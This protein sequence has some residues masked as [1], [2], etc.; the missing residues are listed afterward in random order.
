MN[1]SLYKVIVVGG[2]HAGYEA[3]LASARM[4]VKTL[5]ITLNKSLIGR[6]PCNPAVGGIAKSHLVSELDAL[7]GELG[8]NTDYTGIQYRML[9]TRKGPAVQSNRVQC[10]K[11]LFPLRIQS[12]LDM[13]ENLDIHDDIVT[14]IRTK[15]AAICGVTTRGGGDIDADAVVICTGTFLRGRVLI[16]TKS[17]KEGRMGEESAEELSASFSRFG[18]E[19]GRLKTG[20]PPRIHRDSVDYSSMEIQPGEEPPPFF[21]R[22]ARKE[23]KMFHVEHENPDPSLM[24][25][26]FHVEHGG[27]HPWRPGSDQIPCWL[28]HT[29]A[30]THQIIAD[31]LH[32]SA[33]YSGAVEGTGVRYCPSIEDKIVK[34]SGRDSHHVFIEPEGRNNIRLYP[35]GTS[36]SL[37]EDVQKQMIHSIAGLEKAEIIRPAYAIE[38]D[39]ANPTQLFHTLETKRVENL[40]FAGQLNGTTGYEEAAGQGFVAGANAALK[41]LGQEEFTLSRNESYIGVLIDDLVTKGTDEPYRMFT[42]RSEH[43]LTLRQDNVYFRLLEK[44][45]QLNIVNSDELSEISNHW[46]DIHA[47]IKRLDKVFHDGKSLAQLLR[48]PENLYC[49]LPQAN[50]GLSE[51]VIKQVEIEVKY[52]GYIKRE[53]ERIESARR[54][55]DQLLP[56]DFNYDEIQSLR[57]EAREKLNKIKPE[58]LGQAGRISGV[59]PSDISILGMWLKRKMTNN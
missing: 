15:G 4:G 22:M 27:L 45:K 58:N 17:L 59:N 26:M 46:K 44:S 35:N 13:Q 49:N 1:K 7:G 11:D 16:G 39:Y 33:M 12:V 28:T 55:E 56:P 36:N 42:S 48:Q 53:K 18:F 25:K 2:G 40:F 5:L 3:A 31:N 24:N 47:E 6:L 23:W 32:K 34:F 52:A 9:N 37:P 10:D 21:S 50:Q 19:L 20:T 41:A 29:N 8:R 54:Q 30:N 51:E 57:F 38:Y 43:R 14:A